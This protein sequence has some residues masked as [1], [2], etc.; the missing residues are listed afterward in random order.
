MVSLNLEVVTTI[1]TIAQLFYAEV[2]N[3]KPNLFCS[4]GIKIVR[5]LADCSISQPTHQLNDIAASMDEVRSISLD[6]LETCLDAI[7]LGFSSDNLIRSVSQFLDGID[8]SLTIISP[9]IIC[10]STMVGVIAGNKK[11]LLRL[12]DAISAREPTEAE[13][14]LRFLGLAES[15]INFLKNQ[16]NSQELINSA[17]SDLISC[18][19]GGKMDDEILY[20]LA[21]LKKRNLLPIEIDSSQGESILEFIETRICEKFGDIILRKTSLIQDTEFV[22]LA[23]VRSLLDSKPRNAHLKWL[24][25]YSENDFQHLK[26][27][28]ETASS[29]LLQISPFLSKSLAVVNLMESNMDLMLSY[30]SGAALILL[31]STVMMKIRQ[32]DE[33]IYNELIRERANFCDRVKELERLAAP[34]ISG[35]L[36]DKFY[37]IRN[38]VVHGE[39]GLTMF[40]LE[41]IVGFVSRFMTKI[42]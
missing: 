39:T 29:Q 1:D 4:N 13:I 9:V 7:L 21:A 20:I 19:R 28:F 15:A 8:F 27:I 6:N 37:Q 18:I 14:G 35:V 3:L 23:L 16:S 2:V 36:T 22:N 34:G 11:L 42:L 30:W 33:S 26:M 24:P 5:L 25:K 12:M 10:K 40:D 41:E 17:V 31:E 38:K 32:L